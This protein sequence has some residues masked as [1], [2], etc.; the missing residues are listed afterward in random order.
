M[1]VSL[2][3]VTVT[4]DTRDSTEA[5]VLLSSDLQGPLVPLS[6]HGGST[7]CTGHRDVPQETFSVRRRSRWS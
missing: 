6:V 3:R 5:S 2:G 1:S 4:L 7:M